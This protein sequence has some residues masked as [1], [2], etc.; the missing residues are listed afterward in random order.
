MRNLM[1]AR[2]AG[3]APW[4]WLARKISSPVSRDP[5]IGIPES[6]LTRLVQL[7]CNREVYFCCLQQTAE[8]S[9]NQPANPAH[10]IRPEVVRITAMINH[11]FICFSAA[12]IYDLSYL[13]LHY[14][15][16]TGNRA[17][18]WCSRGHG[19]EPRWGLIFFF[20]FFFFHA[21]ISQLLKLCA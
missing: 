16:S 14:S 20:F 12:Q 19:F 17:L 5:G 1:L 10:V 8:I 9:A 2:L 6:R 21:L 13:Y 4:T 18:H 11:V 3:L 7:S 15:P